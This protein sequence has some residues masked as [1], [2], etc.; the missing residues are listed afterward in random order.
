M[1]G[2]G[3]WN[4]PTADRRRSKNKDCH[5]CEGWIEEYT[6]MKTKKRHRNN[7]Y[8]LISQN[9]PNRRNPLLGPEALLD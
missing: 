8:I 6:L 9:Q 5:T 1:G 3:G 2:E 4:R 7:S